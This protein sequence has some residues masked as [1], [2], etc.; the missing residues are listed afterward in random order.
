[1][2]TILHMRVDA[3][4][5]MGAGHVMRCL[6]IACAWMRHGGHVV[7]LSH[8]LEP[9]LLARLQRLG[10]TYHP[11]PARWPDPRDLDTTRAVLQPLVH[12]DTGTPWLVL[13][14]YHFDVPYMAALAEAGIATCVVDDL[15]DRPYFPA[16]L[17]VNPNSYAP[18]LSYHGPPFLRALLGSAY[19]MLREE[20]LAL[21]PRPI[22][23]AAAPGSNL[24]VTMGG[25][26]ASQVLLALVEILAGTLVENLHVR[27]V[28]GFA[29]ARYEELTRLAATQPYPCEV[30]R[31]VENMAPLL[32]W[33]HAAVSA[34]GG[35]AWELLYA[36][37]PTGLVVLADNQAR[38]AATL[39]NAQAALHLGTAP[40]LLREPTRA[41]IRQLLTDATLRQR[42]IEAGSHVVDGKGADR[43]VAAMKEW[44]HGRKDRR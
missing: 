38:V 43:I 11:L 1:M 20:F 34:A 24:L 10:V 28:A 29:C 18:E 25:G 40:G 30:L 31:A 41:S 2:H 9:K 32:A 5:E 33:A 39:A 22:A 15:A 26:E 42:M 21:P 8:A 19:V 7:L 13:D 17:V 23:Q 35:S 44:S 14:G 16:P 37:V 12:G 36:R 27:I 6:A 3:G 4:A